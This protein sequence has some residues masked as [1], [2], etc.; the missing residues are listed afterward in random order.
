MNDNVWSWGATQTFFLEPTGLS[1]E[2]VSTVL[3]YAL[4]TKRVNSDAIIAAASSA[5]KYS[6]KELNNK[7]SWNIKN[8][9]SLLDSSKYKITSSKTGYLDE[10]GYCLMTRFRNGQ[11]DFVA[12][13]FNAKNRTA[14]VNETAELMSYGVFMVGF[15][16]L[17]IAGKK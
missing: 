3:D 4:I 17:E 13:T 1:P 6:F 5:K 12:V 7:K 15:G 10:A 8:T 14:S 11:D 2:N 16:Q 9:N